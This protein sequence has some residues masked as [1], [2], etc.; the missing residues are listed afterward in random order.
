M[1]VRE[2]ALVSDRA[3]RAGR[4]DPDLPVRS[5]GAGGDAG[6]GVRAA[7]LVRAG[8]LPGEWQGVL[9]GEAGDAPGALRAGDRALDRGAGGEAARGG[10]VAYGRASAGGPGVGGAARAAVRAGCGGGG[11][12]V[13]PRRAPA[14]T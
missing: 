5:G 6:P 9:R 2:R 8:P 13:G 10:R 11:A 14:P 7:G 3:L 4:G 12:G 1:R